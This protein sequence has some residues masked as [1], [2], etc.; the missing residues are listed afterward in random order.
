MVTAVNTDRNAVGVSRHAAGYLRITSPKIAG[1]KCNRE[2]VFVSGKF[3]KDLSIIE[4]AILFPQQWVIHNHTTSR[5]WVVPASRTK[6]ASKGKSHR[7][8]LRVKVARYMWWGERSAQ[9]GS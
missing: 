4:E 9:I 5:E 1:N 7:Q 3:L 2:T 8:K 6:D